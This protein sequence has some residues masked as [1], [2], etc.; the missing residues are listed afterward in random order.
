MARHYLDFVGLN[1]FIYEVNGWDTSQQLI[2][3]DIGYEYGNYNNSNV[4][5]TVHQNFIGQNYGD[6]FVGDDLFRKRKLCFHLSR[7]QTFHQ[8]L[9]SFPL[10]CL[11]EMVHTASRPSS[12]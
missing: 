11:K 5:V 7:M 6:T 4:F 2:G 10:S 8:L 1:T 12:R 9:L 3:S